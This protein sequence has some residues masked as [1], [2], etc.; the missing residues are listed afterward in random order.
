MHKLLVWLSGPNVYTIDSSEHHKPFNRW[1]GLILDWQW[2]L[3]QQFQE[4]DVALL[5]EYVVEM[6]SLPGTYLSSIC[7]DTNST[8]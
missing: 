6:Q 5:W 8:I 1:L 4:R 2:Q 7:A 3:Q